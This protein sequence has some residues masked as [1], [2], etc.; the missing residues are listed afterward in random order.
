[1]TEEMRNTVF[2]EV[3]AEL[4]EARDMP[5][6][7]PYVEGLAESAGIDA[8]KLIRRIED[9]NA[10]HPGGLE[11]M[12]DRLKLSGRERRELSFAFTYERRLPKMPEVPEMTPEQEAILMRAIRKSDALNT[13][14]AVVEDN[15]S[16]NP[17][18]Q[19]DM[20][21]V[22]RSLG[23]SAESD[24]NFLKRDYGFEG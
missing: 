21:D 24:V 20:L 22:L 6:A 9:P 1:M 14:Y 15:P 23:E 7:I 10:E 13:A 3:L 17:R 2:G 8:E 19:E 11:E 5:P 18:V 16:P 12:A 4:L